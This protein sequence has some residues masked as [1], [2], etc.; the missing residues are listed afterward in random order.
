MRPLHFVLKNGDFNNSPILVWFSRNL[1]ILRG[2][3]EFHLLKSNLVFLRPFDS[4][5]SQFCHI[6]FL[7]FRC[8]RNEYSSKRFKSERGRHCGYEEEKGNSEKDDI[9]KESKENQEDEKA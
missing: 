8:S 1:L 3:F 4:V 5:L 2:L 9:E 7:V 6:R